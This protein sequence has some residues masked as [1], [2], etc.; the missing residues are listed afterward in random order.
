MSREPVVRGRR[1]RCCRRRARFV[2]VVGT[3][4]MIAS[5]R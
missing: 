5:E 1:R 2:V 3:R 4:G